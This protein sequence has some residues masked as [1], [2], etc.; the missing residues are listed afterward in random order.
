MQF[1]KFPNSSGWNLTLGNAIIIIII[2]LEF[3]YWFSFMMIVLYHQTKNQSIFSISNN[4]TPY[5]LF[6]R[7]DFTNKSLEPTCNASTSSL[8][9]EENTGVDLMVMQLTTKAQQGQSRNELWSMFI[10]KDHVSCLIDHK[11]SQ[12]HKIQSMWCFL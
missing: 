5:L 7:K 4:C 11:K 1:T 2:I 8:T 6:N 9:K 12:I 10:N 3:Q